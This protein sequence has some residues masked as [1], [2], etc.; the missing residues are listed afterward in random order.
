[1]ESTLI[2]QE[3]KRCSTRTFFLWTLPW[4][5]I[6]GWGGLSAFL[7]LWKGLNQT[8][9]S[10]I[11]AFA[12]WIVFDLGVIALGAGAFF[13]GFLT[14]IIGKKELKSIINAAVIIGFIC[15]SGAMAML[16]ID[17]GQPLRGWFIFWHANIH[18]MLVEVSFCITCYLSVLTIEFLPIILENKK[19]EEIRGLRLFG[20]NLHEAMA[21]FAAT[22]TFLSFFH[23]GSLGG[24]F[25]VMHAR[26]FAAR[27]G[28]YIW[29]WTFF[30]FVLSAIAAGPCFTILCTKLTEKL[31]RKKLVPDDAI[32][33]L[34]KISGWLLS[35]Y[36]IL[37]IADTL[38]WIYGILPKAGLRLMDCYKEG[39][40]GI[41]MLITEIIICGIIPAIILMIPK[42]RKK[43]PWLITASILNCIGILINRFVFIIV[44]LAIPVMPFDRFWSY[45]PTWQE[46]GVGLAIIA[47]GIIVFSVS[48]RYLPVFPKE[49]ELNMA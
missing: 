24:M 49:R 38:G 6:L 20:H 17:I 18:S 27:G 3:P 28:F 15:Y 42:A 45:V 8:N 46:W 12:L 7:C 26:P 19:L 29:P 34:A 11:F 10:N 32:Q 47:Y 16:G 2:H 25:G 5:L 23:Q 31:T 36:M 30:L 43:M 14:Y 40:Y 13:T 41:W 35:I 1:M 9:M 22:G 44:S 37:K 48:Y 39:P 21:I 4:I 33:S